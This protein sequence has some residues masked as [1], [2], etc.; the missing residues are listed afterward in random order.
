MQPQKMARGLKFRIKEVD[1]LY[2][3]CSENKDTDQLHGYCGFLITRF[4]YKASVTLYYSGDPKRGQNLENG[5][6]R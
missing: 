1:G 3:L 5:D 6:C 2:Y 4:K